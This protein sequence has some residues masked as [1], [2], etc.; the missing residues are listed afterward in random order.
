MIIIC[1]ITDLDFWRPKNQPK[2]TKLTNPAGASK[3]KKGGKGK[4]GG[5]GAKA[6]TGKGV[7]TAGRSLEEYEAEQ[8]KKQEA[9]NK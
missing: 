2:K 1:S 6:G 7:I 9:L 3:K 5:K 4:G 8:A